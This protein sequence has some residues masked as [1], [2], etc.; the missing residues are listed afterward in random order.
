MMLTEG[1]LLA[2][3]RTIGCDFKY[4]PKVFLHLFTFV[5]QVREVL[6]KIH[7]H[8]RFRKAPIRAAPGGSGFGHSNTR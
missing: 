2:G 5:G 6:L 8:R 1:I 7:L 4:S 3:K